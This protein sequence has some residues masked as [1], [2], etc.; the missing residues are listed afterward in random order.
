MDWRLPNEN[1]NQ[2]EYLPSCILEIFA[3]SIL[4]SNTILFTLADWWNTS[5]SLWKSSSIMQGY[6]VR[7]VGWLITVPNYAGYWQEKL[8]ARLD[9]TILETHNLQVMRFERLANLLQEAGLVDIQAGGLGTGKFC[10]TCTVRNLGTQSLRLCAKGWNIARRLLPITP[11]W[12]CNVWAAGKVPKVVWQ[13]A[14]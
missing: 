4:S 9:P 5:Q 12:H 8:I 10:T 14:G 6:A 7:E 11:N 3:P 13:K 2:K 1:S